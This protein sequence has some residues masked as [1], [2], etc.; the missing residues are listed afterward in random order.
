MELEI[1]QNAVFTAAAAFGATLGGGLGDLLGNLQ[2]SD[3]DSQAKVAALLAQVGAQSQS[4]ERDAL[5][6]ALTELLS[7]YAGAG[8]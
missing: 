3:I 6:V 1:K 2:T 7:Y 4:S 5:I 8:A